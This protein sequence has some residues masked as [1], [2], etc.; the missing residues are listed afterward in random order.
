MRLI[1]QTFAFGC[2][3]GTGRGGGGRRKRSRR[4]EKQA[5]AAAA[6]ARQ[7]RA[8][9]RAGPSKVR[10]ARSLALRHA[11]PSSNLR[12]P[13]PGSPSS[14]SPSRA[15]SVSLLRA[16]P[17]RSVYRSTAESLLWCSF[18]VCLPACLP[19]GRLGP[20]FPPATPCSDSRALSPLPSPPP[21]PT[22][23]QPRLCIAGTG[24]QHTS[25]PI[26]GC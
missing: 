10:L 26:A 13:H 7:G 15:I 18:S 1:N 19:V 16:R 3:G 25:R 4:R 5:A 24:N 14:L 21:A 12:Y 22:S 9:G 20:A 23:H 11:G 2:R 17:S 6:E 8:R